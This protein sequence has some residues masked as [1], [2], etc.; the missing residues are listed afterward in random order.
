MKKGRGAAKL[1][2]KRGQVKRTGVK[3]KLKVYDK[4]TLGFKK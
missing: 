3:Q 1:G 2:P 4:K